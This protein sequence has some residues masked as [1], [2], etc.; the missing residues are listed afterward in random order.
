[1]I[2]ERVTANAVGL[3]RLTPAAFHH[4][5]HVLGVSTEVEV[6]WV[7]AHS[8]IT[9]VEDMQALRDRPD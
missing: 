4:F 6:R 5:G 8:N 9:R 3:R 2:C 7:A 1:V